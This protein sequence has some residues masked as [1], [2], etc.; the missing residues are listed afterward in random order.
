MF[1]TKPPACSAAHHVHAPALHGTDSPLE[2]CILAFSR[3]LHKRH[4]SG[5]IDRLEVNKFRL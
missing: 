3:V 2:V 5:R 4:S 1:N